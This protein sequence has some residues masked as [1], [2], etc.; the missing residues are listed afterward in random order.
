MMQKWKC[1]CFAAASCLLLALWAAMMWQGAGVVQEL[2]EQEQSLHQVQE[3]YAALERL[4]AE[5]PDVEKYQMEV[6]KELKHVGAL[7]PDDMETA[8]FLQ[9]MKAAADRT[10]MVL[11]ELAPEEA[12]EENGLLAM[13]VRVTLQGDYFSLVR[14]LRA[15]QN[16]S[17]FMQVVAMDVA[18]KGDFL[19]CR[20]QFKIFFRKTL[21]KVLT[22]RQ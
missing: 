19:D 11:C 9:E 5:H 14:F 6:E 17:R 8:V 22:K 16:G 18:S 15:L 2:E 20:L 10:G 12:A 7:L 1:R 13:P 4:Q 3:E 21:I